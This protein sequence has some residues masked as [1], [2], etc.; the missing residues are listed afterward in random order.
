MAGTKVTIHV[1]NTGMFISQ[2]DLLLC[3][4]AMKQ[5]KIPAHMPVT[6]KY[7]TFKQ[8]VRCIPYHGKSELRISPGFAQ[9][10]GFQPGNTVR[11]LYKAGTQVLHLGPLIGVLVNRV[12]SETSERKFGNLTAFCRELSD[13]CR[14][15]GAF[16][17]YFTPQQIQPGR[18]EME[19]WSYSG[20]WRKGT[21][22]IP[23]V[24]HNRLTTRKLENKPSVQQFMR[25]VKSRWNTVVFNEKYLDKTEV[26]QAL[27]KDSGIVRYLPESYAF[28][29]YQMLKSMC[30]KYPVVF[31]KPIRGSLGKGIIRIAR[32]ES[33]TY[34]CH[35]NNL[36][37]FKKQ[38]FPS[39]SQLFSA[40]SG[41]M[42]STRY[43]IQQGLQL[44]EAGGRPIDF[45]A[46]VQKNRL[47]RW[48]ITSIVARI[49]AN[50][51][52]VSNLA[53]GGMLCKVQEAL[54]KS[55][56][57][58]G[59]EKTINSSL[60]K[61]SL[62]IANAIDNQIPAHFGELGI[63]LAVDI[64]GRIWLIEVN[65]K[66]SKNDN[67]PLSDNKI[68]PSVKQLVQYARYLTGF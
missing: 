25:E 59:N 36:N 30:N 32:Q 35:L 19:G 48:S 56:L 23:D 1:Q 63:D 5:S 11:L 67:T 65:S 33:G 22:P 20:R 58:S 44:I 9:K 68:R 12:V 10:L 66:P 18:D 17:Y 15:Q 37:S 4:T 16:V 46:L 61:A 2:Q 8:V 31:L 43:Q 55:N 42:K 28:K 53:R 34:T 51:Q 54:A 49:A 3:E 50:H 21:Y 45:R 41:K 39:L 62:D 47:G 13:A 60:R 6:L 52:F 26:F 14:L 40:I 29:N 7:G 27:R 24:V 38:Q 57:S 64:H